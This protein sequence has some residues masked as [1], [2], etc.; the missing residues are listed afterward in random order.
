MPKNHH[1][2]TEKQQ[3]RLYAVHHMH[4]VKSK[5]VVKH[6][7]HHCFLFSQKNMIGDKYRIKHHL[8][9]S[10]LYHVLNKNFSGMLYDHLNRR[11]KIIIGKI[12]NKKRSAIF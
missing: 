6:E 4:H 5:R 7:L 2:L 10:K 11:F 8:S 12:K 3:K 1:F 9:D